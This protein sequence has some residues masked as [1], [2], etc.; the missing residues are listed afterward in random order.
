M[1]TR[2]KQ[3]KLQC[4]VTSTQRSLRNSDISWKDVAE[5]KGIYVRTGSGLELFGECTGI[6]TGD[7]LDLVEFHD[8]SFVGARDMPMSKLRNDVHEGESIFVLIDA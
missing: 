4:A 8:T 5:G 1:G 2:R 6:L 3:K 7:R